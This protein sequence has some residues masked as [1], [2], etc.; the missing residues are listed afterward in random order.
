MQDFFTADTYKSDMKN[1]ADTAVISKIIKGMDETNEKYKLTEEEKLEKLAMVVGNSDT[2]TANGTFVK[3]FE[4]VS[5]DLMGYNYMDNRDIFNVL[6]DTQKQN[7]QLSGEILDDIKSCPNMYPRKYQAVNIKT[8]L[9]AKAK[10]SLRQAEKRIEELDRLF[11]RL[12]EDNVSG[13]I[14]DERFE[15]LSNGYEDEQK[16]LKADVAEL[17]AKIENA[18]QKTSD[19]S[20]F[21]RLVKKYESFT[22]L[23]PEIMHGLI[24]KIVVHAPD[25]SSG[26]RT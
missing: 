7:Y 14:S 4:M 25:K 11:K 23:T 12:Y 13:K 9:I 17:S 16:S 21:V 8:L 10:K 6:F 2:W 26:H 18:E 15:R 20:S 22:E 1:L 3:Q 5:S 24:D 19:V